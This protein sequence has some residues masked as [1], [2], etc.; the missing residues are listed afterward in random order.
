MAVNVV[1]IKGGELGLGEAP[2]GLL[3][4]LLRWGE[5]NIRIPPFKERPG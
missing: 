1:R 5:R 3:G 2:L 4:V